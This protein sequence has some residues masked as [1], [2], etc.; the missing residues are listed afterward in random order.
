[1][2]TYRLFSYFL[3]VPRGDELVR[4]IC[5]FETSL[6]RVW[7]GE[8]LVREICGFETSLVRVWEGEELGDGLVLGVRASYKEKSK[9]CHN[10]NNCN[11]SV[12]MECK[13]EHTIFWVWT[14]YSFTL[15]QNL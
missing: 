12:Y 13:F 4:E 7:E 14:E 9:Q 11:P 6:V 3:S 8:E 10:N 1:M 15:M 2:T 5:G